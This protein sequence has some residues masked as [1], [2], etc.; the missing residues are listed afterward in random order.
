M[1][2]K[3]VRSGGELMLFFL[4]LVV[5]FALIAFDESALWRPLAAIAIAALL[6]AKP[7]FQWA[8]S[9]QF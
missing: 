4:V 8:V 7:L 3:L 6:C 9:E 5:S 2:A 1:A